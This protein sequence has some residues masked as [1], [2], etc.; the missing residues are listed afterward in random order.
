MNPT[1]QVL[2]DEE[3]RIKKWLVNYLGEILEIDPKTIDTGSSL[4][5]LGLDSA[6]AVGM[7]G[8]LESFLNRKV[9]ATLPYDFPSVDAFAKA[10]A[11]TSPSAAIAAAQKPLSPPLR[12]YFENST[13]R[14]LFNVM[15]GRDVEESLAIRECRVWSRYV[16]ATFDRTYQTQMLQ[17]PDHLVVLTAMAH[18]QKLTYLCM[19]HELGIEYDPLK[20]ERMK[21]WPTNVRISLPRLVTETKDLVQSLWLLNIS[22][23]SDKIYDTT[24]LTRVNQMEI[25]ADSPIFLI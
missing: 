23:R 3:H 2:V 16:E 12:T 19:C 5:R 24:V 14:V 7:T 10:L 22:K 25:V 15:P 6:A 21:I 20:P 4:Y 18:T 9:S 13:L 11:A 1:S 17:S 8:E